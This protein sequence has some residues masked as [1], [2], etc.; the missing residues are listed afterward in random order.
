MCHMDIGQGVLALKRISL[1]LL[2]FGGVYLIAVI[3]ALIVERIRDR[4]S[5]LIRQERD[6]PNVRRI[7]RNARLYQPGSDSSGSEHPR[8]DPALEEMIRANLREE[9]AAYARECLQQAHASQDSHREKLYREYL[10]YLAQ[11]Q[12]DTIN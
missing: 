1:L 5:D 6:A 9:A 7:I 2:I 4:T 11:S 12:N 10:H 8:Y 3:I